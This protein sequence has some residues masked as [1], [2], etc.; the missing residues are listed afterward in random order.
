[1]KW[2]GNSKTT[3]PTINTSGVSSTNNN[4][5]SGH[6]GSSNH[7]E[8]QNFIRSIKKDRMQYEVIKDDR[9]F[10]NWQ[11]SFLAV[12]RTHKLEE[13]FDENYTPDGNK[14]EEFQLWQEK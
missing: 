9:Q 8:L 7:S 6:S 14:P 4:T 3:Q 10:D 11:R 12:A 5:N 13:A 2:S 1:L